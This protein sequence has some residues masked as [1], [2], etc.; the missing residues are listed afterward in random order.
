MQR[1]RDDHTR[2]EGPEEGALQ[3]EGS[4]GAPPDDRDDQEASESPRR[5]RVTGQSFQ[6]GEGPF[7]EP[8]V[9]TVRSQAGEEGSAGGG[10][11][12]V[13]GANGEP[14]DQERSPAMMT[15]QGREGRGGCEL[16]EGGD[17]QGGTRGHRFGPVGPSDGQSHHQE[18]QGFQVSAPRHFH[19]KEWRP[20]VEEEGGSLVSTRVPGDAG[21]DGGGAQIAG[22]PED[23]GRDD[24]RSDQSQKDERHLGQRGVDGRDRRIVDEVVPGRSKTLE[25]HG[26]RR[27]EVRVDAR[28]ADVTVPEV[29]V[30]VVGQLRG[31]GEQD[32]PHGDGD[33]PDGADVAPAL[34]CAVACALSRAVAP[35]LSRAIAPVLPVAR[36]PATR[37]PGGHGVDDE[38]R[39]EDR[40]SGQREAV[41]GGKP[42]EGR[43]EGE[44]GEPQTEE[45]V[46]GPHRPVLHADVPGDRVVA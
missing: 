33:E 39:A 42:T 37:K 12:E 10:E 20:E 16:G 1:R 28:E 43:K 17:S 19:D 36:T 6:H 32:Q 9:F 22:E 44:F 24:G 45:D 7:H 3:G 5:L 21:E 38:S 40:Q 11:R 2:A 29:P 8:P 41:R 30:D 25:L 26:I 34:T 23:L 13:Q 27:V 15:H 18:A 35:V 31:E 46:G 4:E 14:E